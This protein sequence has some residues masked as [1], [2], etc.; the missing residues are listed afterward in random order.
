[1]SIFIGQPYKVLAAFVSFYILSGI[2][3]HIITLGNIDSTNQET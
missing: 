3:K 1:V 2:F